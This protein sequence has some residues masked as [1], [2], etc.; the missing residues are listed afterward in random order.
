MSYKYQRVRERLRQ[1]IETGELSGKLPGERELSRKFGAN[2]KTINKALTD[3]ATE[4]LLV[5]HVGR[6]TFVYD[7]RLGASEGNGQARA[8]KFAYLTPVDGTRVCAEELY[9]RT[10]DVLG[11]LGHRLEQLPV[12]VEPSG[13]LS[14]R[15]LSADRLRAFDGLTLYGARPAAALLASIIREHLPLV[16]VNNQHA[17]IRTAAVLVDYSQGAFELCE[18]LIRLGHREIRLCIDP[19]LM[20]A[21]ENADMGYRAAMLRHGLAPLPFYRAQ[22]PFDAGAVLAGRQ[23]NRPTAVICVGCEV[24]SILQAASAQS[25]GAL[26]VCCIPEPCD[27]ATERQKLTSYEADPDRLARWITDLLTSASPTRWQRVVIV[28]GRI[29][30]RGSAKPLEGA[31]KSIP[32]P[33]VAVI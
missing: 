11:A 20:P 14:G 1:A 8:L 15:G 12:P 16:M 10:A 28:P 31:G 22:A 2:P 6:G 13:E 23:G 25:P 19:L 3:L 17:Q 18:H 26:S 9:R 4:G 30:D 33:D 29:V 27:A 21:A 32:A 5:R 7:P 24:A